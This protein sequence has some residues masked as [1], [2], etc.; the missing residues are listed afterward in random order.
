MY[1]SYLG[2]DQNIGLYARLFD[3][4]ILS[5]TSIST[6]HLID[7]QQYPMLITDFP[8]TLQELCGG[9]YV[10]PLAE[11]RLNEDRSSVAWCSLL[12]E[13]ERELI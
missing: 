9:G 7:D 11:D 10:S 12:A 4:E 1:P 6:L 8:Q 3:N 2:T 13:E 5:C